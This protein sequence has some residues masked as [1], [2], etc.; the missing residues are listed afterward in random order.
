[1][2]REAAL[3]VAAVFSFTWLVWIAGNLYSVPHFV[4]LGTMIPSIMGVLFIA[5]YNK[6]SGLKLFFSSALHFKASCKW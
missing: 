4:L 6:K 1:M 3:F 5:L 2:Q